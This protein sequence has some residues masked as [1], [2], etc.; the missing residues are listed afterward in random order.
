[1]K[2][3]LMIWLFF[4]IISL[5]SVCYAIS[6][7]FFAP[8]SFKQFCIA[9]D[10][11]RYLADFDSMTSDGGHKVIWVR[12]IGAEFPN[13]THGIEHATEYQYIINCS[14]DNISLVK[15]ALYRSNGEKFNSRVVDANSTI[16]PDSH[17]D[18]L[19]IKENVE[20]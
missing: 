7:V 1:M 19:M 9:S 8:D 2:R 14:S 4:A 13:H 12:K 20:Q 17:L 10:G 11:V 15:Y 5:T 3:I 6:E 16:I 18:C